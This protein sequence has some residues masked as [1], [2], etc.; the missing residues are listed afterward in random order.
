MYTFFMEKFTPNTEPGETPAKKLWHAHRE[1][2]DASDEWM[3]E[4]KMV[5]DVLDSF[6]EEA[7]RE[8]LFALASK[9]G[10][11]KQT[12]SFPSLDQVK[13]IF[14]KISNA[15]AHNSRTETAINA[16]NIPYDGSKVSVYSVLWAIIHEYLHEL[17]TATI[18]ENSEIS[19]GIYRSVI[20]GKSGVSET[21]TST[22]ANLNTREVKNNEGENNKSI[23]EGITEW[24][25]GKV[26]DEYLKR[27]GDSQLRNSEHE[28]RING[29]RGVY[30]VERLN[31]ELYILFLS[32]LLEQ[33]AS[34][35]ESSIIRTYVRNGEIVPEEIIDTLNV[36]TKKRDLVLT[37]LREKIN[38]PDFAVLL[39]D[40]EKSLPPEKQDGFKNKVSEKFNQVV[41]AIEINNREF[42][43]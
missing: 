2:Y 40:L 24:L 26:F 17:S 36:A 33:P 43:P 18:E 25:T 6:N 7:L 4:Q 29:L 35:I 34:V 3:V 30:W 41:D 15:A 31:V 23:N 42:E 14:D 12:I 13:V 22:E 9:A 11:D 20:V 28:K 37:L 10:I 38:E 21:V 1:N 19:G 16:A 5:R 8:I 27:V 32:E 39:L